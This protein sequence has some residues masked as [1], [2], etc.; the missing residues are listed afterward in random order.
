MAKAAAV[1]ASFAL[2]TSV[3]MKVAQCNNAR[4]ETGN[5]QLLVKQKCATDRKT[6]CGPRQ[7]SHRPLKQQ[8][9]LCAHSF[10]CPIACVSRSTVQIHHF[11]SLWWSW[12]CKLL[13]PA[14]F[15]FLTLVASANTLHRANSPFGRREHVLQRENLSLQRST[16]SGRWALHLRR[17]SQV[18]SSLEQCSI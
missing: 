15:F 5:A 6:C 17:A 10:E 11:S 8:V 18:Y 7:S 4:I 16:P 12:D 14:L 1:V 9:V 13:Y 3:A 2:A